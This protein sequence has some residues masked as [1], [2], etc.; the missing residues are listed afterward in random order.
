MRLPYPNLFCTRLWPVGTLGPYFKFMAVNVNRVLVVSCPIRQIKL[1][2]SISLP[3]RC[4]RYY[5]YML[6]L[7]TSRQPPFVHSSLCYLN[8]NW[9]G[10][11]FAIITHCPTTTMSNCHTEDHT[12]FQNH[13]T[14]GYNP[15]AQR[16][17][18]RP[19]PIWHTNHNSGIVSNVGDNFTAASGSRG[20]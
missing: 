14:S 13:Q 15:T 2:P 18:A 20:F 11:W 6:F 10:S 16:P 17:P 8:L 19:Y 9:L 5:S 12:R 1:L 7:Y 3:A 4:S